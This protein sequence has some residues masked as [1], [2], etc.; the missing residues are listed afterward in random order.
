MNRAEMRSVGFRLLALLAAL[1][2]LLPGGAAA[3]TQYLCHATGRVLASC[4]CKSSARVSPPETRIRAKGC[5]DLVSSA[6]RAAMPRSCSEA[7]RLPA[8]AF[9]AS[10][11]PFIPVM[12]DAPSSEDESPRP[13]TRAPPALG[14]PLFLA[15]CAFLI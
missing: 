4:C 6:E 11:A 8:P 1:L 13:R 9:L 3:R 5:C 7:T 12:R 15:H 10:T 14:P 2:V